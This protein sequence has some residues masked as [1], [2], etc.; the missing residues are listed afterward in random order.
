MAKRQKSGVVKHPLTLIILLVL[1]GCELM[2]RWGQDDL[3]SA[4]VAYNEVARYVNMVDS[5]SAPE[6]VKSQDAIVRLEA[7]VHR[8]QDTRLR[9]NYAISAIT[10]R[11]ASETFKKTYPWMFDSKF[12]LADRLRAQGCELKARAIYQQ[13]ADNYPGAPF[14]GY[15]DRAVLALTGS[16][17]LSSI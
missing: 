15:R 1:A 2:P 14:S 12:M 13:I 6:I 7:I 16:K 5:C 10:E 4:R 11:D 9:D 8:N 17:K 3:D